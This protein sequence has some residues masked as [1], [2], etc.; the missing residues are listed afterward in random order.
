MKRSLSKVLVV[1]LGLSLVLAACG[2]DDKKNDSTPTTAKAAKSSV[3]ITIGAQD[4]QESKIL[5]EIYAQGLKAQGYTASVK[6]LGASAYRKVE[7]E[8]FKAGTINFAPE[9]AAS[10]LEELNSKKGEA[11][12]DAKATTDKLNTYLPTVG[13]GLVAL[14]PSDAVDTNAFVVTKKTADDLGLTS[15]SDLAAKGKDL[16]L[17]AP[18]DCA[19]NPNCVPGLKKV[20]NADFSNY[21]TLGAGQP[22][23]QALEAG[24]I[25]MGVLFSTDSTIAVKNFVLL[26]DDKHMLSADNVVPVVAKALNTAGFAEAVN[27]ISAKLT[28]AELIKLNKQYD[29]DKADPAVI[30]K[31]FLTKEKLL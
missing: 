17:G 21:T 12:G 16:K 8:A 19:T 9:Y 3:P 14:E 22:I 15:L 18:S 1:T 7:L 25:T 10:M 28:T 20:Y 24:A 4:F 23:A 13:S 31:G 6:P 2:K 5:A 11:T 27:K 30:A 26:K 29:V